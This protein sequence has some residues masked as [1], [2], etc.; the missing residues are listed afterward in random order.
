MGVWKSIA[1]RMKAKKDELQRRAVRKAAE[2]ALDSAGKAV[3]SAGKAVGKALF[4]DLDDE[5]A[6]GKAAEAPPDPFA[7]LKAQEKETKERERQ[8][9]RRA[10]ERA[11]AEAKLE[12]D[13]DEEL[14]ALKKRL[15]K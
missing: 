14:A 1:D 11:E 8:E 13:V 4:G 10:Q 3:Q 5:A 12:K 15:D 9:K 6:T 2:T 7:K